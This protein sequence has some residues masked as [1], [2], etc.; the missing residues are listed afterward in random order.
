[1]LESNLKLIS[2]DIKTLIKDAQTLLQ[3]AAALPGEKA[4]E[5]RN[6]AMRLLDT[7]LA[8]AQEAQTSVLDAG[9]E[10]AVS[11]DDYVKE[12]PWRAIATA[13]GVGLLVGVILARK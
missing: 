11:A 1:M 8:K 7:A 2:N 9:K 4:E 3:A 5:V 12:N 6:R 10:M 13:A